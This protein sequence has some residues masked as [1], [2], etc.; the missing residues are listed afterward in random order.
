MAYRC[1][2]HAEDLLPDQRSGNGGL[3]KVTDANIVMIQEEVRK[4][5]E[6]Q[7]ER[8][9][10]IPRTVA[11]VSREVVEKQRSARLQEREEDIP[12]RAMISNGRA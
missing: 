7:A 8:L 9:T 5:I 10:C 1:Q 4:S 11:D 12:S 2:R 3:H 6:F